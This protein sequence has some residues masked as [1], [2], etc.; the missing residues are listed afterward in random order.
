M[1]E[2]KPLYRWSLDNAIHN[3]ERD[4][5][6]DSYKENCDCARAISQTISEAYDHDTLHLNDC[7]KLMI[8]KYGF[9]RVNYVLAN[10]IQLSH[11]DR[12]SS[13]TNRVWA[14]GFHIPYDKQ[15][16]DFVV[17][18]H[19]GLT[20]IFTRQVLCEWRA[21]GL[22]DVSHCE[23]NDSE[24]DY[25]G[26]VV[27]IRP[28]FL[29]DEYK[30]PE[31]QLFYISGGNGARPGA[32]GRKVYGEFLKD[33]EK[34]HYFRDEIIGVLKEEYLPEWAAAKLANKQEPK[35]DE[36]SGMTIQ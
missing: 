17:T 9:N 34:T 20:D 18:A 22:F 8:E 19:P 4:L 31:D 16:H 33:S 35:E 3:N 32:I 28:E 2:H 1:A 24:Q 25:T 30:T 13:E 11:N 23:E 26:K 15:R 27:V 29:K 21:L 10:T 5:W 36:S 7:A 12:R 6:R 14:R